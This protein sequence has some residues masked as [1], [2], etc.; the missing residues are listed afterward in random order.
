MYTGITYDVHP[1]GSSETTLSLRGPI[2]RSRRRDLVLSAYSTRS[3]KTYRV[4]RR[5]KLMIAKKKKKNRIV[6]TSAELNDW[7]AHK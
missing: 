4:G 6:L 3:V 2:N 7:K 5:S 1:R